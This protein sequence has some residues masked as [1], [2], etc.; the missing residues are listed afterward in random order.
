MSLSRKTVLPALAA[1]LALSVPSFTLAHGGTFD[2]EED[3][4]EKVTVL[5][6]IMTGG[7]VKHVP[8]SMGISPKGGIG[9]LTFNE[10]TKVLC[11]SVSHDPIVGETTAHFHGPA[12]PGQGSH[13]HLWPDETTTLGNG[14][15]KDGCTDPLSAD[16]ERALKAG[17]WFLEIHSTNYPLGEIRGQVIPVH[18][19]QYG[20]GNG[21]N[22]PRDGH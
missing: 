13:D 10:T 11:F 8:P 17:L 22:I 9:F 2:Y 21:Q 18:G 1:I 3:S 7:Q 5:T 14:S 20:P 15:P 19:L 12:A 4:S 16:E 6:M